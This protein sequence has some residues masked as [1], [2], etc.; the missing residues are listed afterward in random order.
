MIKI[1]YP[2]NLMQAGRLRKALNEQ[3]NFSVGVRTLGERLAEI[4]PLYRHHY[5]RHYSPHKR[6]GCN[7]L[8]DPPHHEYSVWYAQDGQELGLDVPK[9]VFDALDL[10]TK[11]GEEYYTPRPKAQT[12]AWYIR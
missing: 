4:K 9:I 1:T 6:N 8:Y 11:E 5:I 3:Y 7:A 10:P 2:D 12:G